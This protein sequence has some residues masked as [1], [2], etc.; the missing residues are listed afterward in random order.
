[1]GVIL[2]V[3]PEAVKLHYRMAR[4]DQPGLFDET[5]GPL[6]PALVDLGK[7]IPPGIRFGTSTWTYDGWTGDVYHRPYRGP[8]PARRLEEYARY[9]LFGTVGIDSAFYEPPSEE[10]LTA[11]A[12]ALPSGFLAV[13]KVWDRITA[14]RFGSSPKWGNQSGMKNPD[15][16]NADL[17]IESVLGPYQRAFKEHAGRAVGKREET[18]VRPSTRESRERD[19]L[20]AAVDEIHR[21]YRLAGLRQRS[22]QGVHRPARQVPE[23]RSDRGE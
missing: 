6:D 18:R 3:G 22:C 4:P 11:Y 14:K 13:S 16:L 8:E 1:M 19:G 23:E 12:R 2:A 15:F 9:P 17:F 21:E 10:T 5:A 7:A 20:Q